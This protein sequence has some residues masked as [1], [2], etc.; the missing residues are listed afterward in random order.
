ML[1]GT[2]IQTV[3]EIKG[4]LNDDIVYIVLL[5]CLVARPCG[6]PRFNDTLVT[7]TV[8]EDGSRFT[9]CTP[10]SGL[11]GFHIMRQ[12][13]GLFGELELSHGLLPPQTKL[14]AWQSRLYV[15][16]SLSR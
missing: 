16:S 2:K 11:M 3:L 10:R 14:M 6:Q 4:V 7:K 8:Q 15:L 13:V 1:K 9:L 12:G 5:L